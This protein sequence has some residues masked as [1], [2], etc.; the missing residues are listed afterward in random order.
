MKRLLFVFLYLIIPLAIFSQASGGQIRRNTPSSSIS[1]AC[2]ANNSNNLYAKTGSHNGY[3]YVDLGLSVNWATCNVGTKLIW[4]MSEAYVWGNTVPGYEDLSDPLRKH[5]RTD[6]GNN[7]SKGEYDAAH[8]NMGGEW[9][10]PSWIEAQEL[11]DR[12]R[13]KYTKYRGV[14]GFDVIGPNNNKIFIPVD[15]YSYDENSNLYRVTVELW[16]SSG[17]MDNKNNLFWANFIEIEYNPHQKKYMLSPRISKEAKYY[18][19]RIR[20]VYNK[21]E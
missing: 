3:D 8:K 15:S 11:I 4:E 2:N 21:R 17:E 19:K 13:W 1:N 6:L 16:T 10:M 12:C 9:R 5:I 7:I 14:N 20:G 18:A